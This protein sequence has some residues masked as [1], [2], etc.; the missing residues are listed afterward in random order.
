MELMQY[1]NNKGDK[2]LL[3]GT[4]YLVLTW[5]DNGMKENMKKNCFIFWLQT[6]KDNSDF[7]VKP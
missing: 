4:P 6:N 3:C 2:I 5:T 1:M 7:R